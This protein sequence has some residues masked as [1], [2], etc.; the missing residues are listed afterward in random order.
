VF[1]FGIAVASCFA[2][3]QIREKAIDHCS[4]V[5]LE[6]DSFLGL[7]AVPVVTCDV[8]TITYD[9]APCLDEGATQCAALNF[10]DSKLA[11]VSKQQNFQ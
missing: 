4:L 10:P 1:F 11:P 5:Q 6:A 7:G 9:T 2:Y 3:R 8:S